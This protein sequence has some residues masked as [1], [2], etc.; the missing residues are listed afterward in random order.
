[1]EKEVCLAVN[2]QERRLVFID[3]PVSLVSYLKYVIVMPVLNPIT[4]YMY[5]LKKTGKMFVLAIQLV[6]R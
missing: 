5:L 6:Q 2:G 1:M 3:H 4:N